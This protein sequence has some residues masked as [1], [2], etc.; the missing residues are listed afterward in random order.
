MVE[1]VLEPATFAEHWDFGDPVAC[2]L[3][4]SSEWIFM[5]PMGAAQDS[6]FSA[7]H[8]GIVEGTIQRD[9]SGLNPRKVEFEMKLS[10]LPAASQVAVSFSENDD[11]VDSAVFDF[12]FRPRSNLPISGSDHNGVHVLLNGKKQKKHMDDYLDMWMRWRCEID[13]NE[14]ELAVEPEEETED[15]K[16]LRQQAE[17]VLEANEQR[18]KELNKSD[19]EAQNASSSSDQ[20]QNDAGPKTATVPA[21]MKVYLNDEL[22]AEDIPCY[23]ANKIYSVAFRLDGNA[24]IYVKSMDIME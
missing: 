16:R 8:I 12:I 7:K 4:D 22:F 19:A 15:L 20:A 11:L 1:K 13:W 5:G 23:T 2:Y 10:N 17:T 18:R 21:T 24:K 14:K 3:D 9:L 6:S